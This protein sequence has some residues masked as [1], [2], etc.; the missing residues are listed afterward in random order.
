MNGI[1]NYK[2]TNKLFFFRSVFLFALF[3]KSCVFGGSPL[4]FAETLNWVSRKE[5]IAALCEEYP[6]V[7]SAAVS[8]NTGCPVTSHFITTVQK[9]SL[10]LP[11]FLWSIES[12]ATENILCLG[13]LIY[14][15]NSVLTSARLPLRV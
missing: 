4:F 10:F 13:G 11:V 6:A 7:T 1:L 15:S 2:F 12:E 3:A 14:C 5:R 8:L 9:D